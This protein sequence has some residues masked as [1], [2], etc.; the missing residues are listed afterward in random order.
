LYWPRASCAGAYLALGSGSLAILALGD[1]RSAIG[2]A[3]LSE[4]QI[5]LGTT[6][7]A[8]SLLI[9]G[10]LVWPDRRAPG[11]PALDNRGTP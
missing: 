9:V 7:L 5:I 10:S 2:L 3:W 6:A 8:L 1:L 4:P 11:N